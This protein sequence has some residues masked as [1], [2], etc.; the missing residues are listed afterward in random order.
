MYEDNNKKN[1]LRSRIK[2]NYKKHPQ[3]KMA[4]I[5]LKGQRDLVSIMIPRIKKCISERIMS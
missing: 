1:E 4:E 3:F 5:A 2:I